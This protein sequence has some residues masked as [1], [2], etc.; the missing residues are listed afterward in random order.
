MSDLDKK[1]EENLESYAECY[2][3]EH[4]YNDSYCNENLSQTKE[5]VKQIKQAFIDDGWLDITQ[6]GGIKSMNIATPSG[7]RI[8]FMIGQEWYDRLKECL[9]KPTI[10]EYGDKVYYADSVNVA[11]KKASGLSNDL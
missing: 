6:F 4:E 7:R 9:G 1:L 8:D 10:V 5:L 3:P 2:H 11:A